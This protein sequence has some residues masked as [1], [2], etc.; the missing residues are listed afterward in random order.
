[1][2]CTVEIFTRFDVQMWIVSCESFLSLFLHSIYTHHP[3][4]DGNVNLL[5]TDGLKLLFTISILQ[6]TISRTNGA[7]MLHGH[8]TC[9]LIGI[10]AK[11]RQEKEEDS[12]KNLF[13]DDLWMN[14]R[15]TKNR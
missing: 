15:G 6:P 10:P 7:A 14:E 9:G 12:K 3:L 5:L 4:R 11:H 1:M 13:L 8:F 2:I